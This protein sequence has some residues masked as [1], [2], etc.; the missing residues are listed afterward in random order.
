MHKTDYSVVIS[1]IIMCLTNLKYIGNTIM[2]PEVQ[3]Y[4]FAPRGNM[5]DLISKNF[6]M[7]VLM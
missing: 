5:L 2:T 4:H 6:Y 7:V 3:N 1:I